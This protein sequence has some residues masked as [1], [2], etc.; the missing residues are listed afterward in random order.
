[1]FSTLAR[2]LW[3]TPQP[4]V[5]S[6]NDNEERQEMPLPLP[7]LAAVP[8]SRKPS[9]F[10]MDRSRGPSHVAWLTP[11]S[12]SPAVSRRS[13]PP[14]FVNRTSATPSSLDSAGP[15]PAGPSQCP[16]SNRQSSGSESLHLQGLYYLSDLISESDNAPSTMPLPAAESPAVRFPISIRRPSTDSVPMTPDSVRPSDGHRKYASAFR[17]TVP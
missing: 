1:M 10:T 2:Y 5:P 6:D 3:S 12:S 9:S 15:G 14:K 16:A 7:M 4:D 11:N 17:S 13:W 8:M